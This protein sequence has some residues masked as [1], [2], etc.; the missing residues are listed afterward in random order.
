M[1]PR[2]ETVAA[3]RCTTRCKRVT[4]FRQCRNCSEVITTH[5]AS[6]SAATAVAKHSTRSGAERQT[7]PPTA[8]T[9]MIK[10]PIAGT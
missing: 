9:T 3:R 1:T 8:H 5:P 7:N 6:T 10:T 2:H 4:L